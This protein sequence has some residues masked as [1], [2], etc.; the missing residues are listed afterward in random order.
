MA[1]SRVLEPELMDTPEEAWAYDQMDHSAV[2]Q[3]FVDDLLGAGIPGAKVLDLGTGTARIAILLCRQTPEVRVMAADLALAMLELARYNVELAGLTERIQLD[4]VDAK[5]LPYA[6]DSFDCVMSN[7]LVHHIAEPIVV[8]GEA[9]RVV[10]PGG[11]LFFRDLMRPDS[12]S[13]LERLVELYAGNESPAARQ[14]FAASL[15]AALT[16]DEIRHLVQ[17]LGYAADS[18]Q[19]TSD[20]H[21]TWVAHKPAAGS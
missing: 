9:C 2:N 7:S 20:R 14:M 13:E 17:K 1:L 16:L 11:L 10:R 19:A 4:H 3:A 15:H 5:K 21:W 6:S 18:V 8:L 12:Q